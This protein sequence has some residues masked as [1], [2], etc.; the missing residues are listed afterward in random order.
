[1]VLA[2]QLVQCCPNGH[3]RFETAPQVGAHLEAFTLHPH[4]GD[5]ANN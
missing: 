5:F 1:M 3:L 4:L 2:G